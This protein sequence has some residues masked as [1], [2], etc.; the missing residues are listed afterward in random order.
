VPH[1]RFPSLLVVVVTETPVSMLVI[2]HFGADDH[3]A[4]QVCNSAGDPCV[5]GLCAGRRNGQK[6][7]HN[8]YMRLHRTPSLVLA[9]CS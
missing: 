6:S 7:K 5:L 3:G 8:E 9:P 1:S 4:S 2:S